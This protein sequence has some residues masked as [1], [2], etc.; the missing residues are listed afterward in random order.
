MTFSLNN[1]TYEID[2]T[3]ENQTKLEGVLAPFIDAAREIKGARN[4]APQSRRSA[5]RTDLDDIRAWA[6]AQGHNVSD[7]GRVPQSI[8]DAYEAAQ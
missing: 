3:Q 4:S 2:L 1:K 7:R 8:V 6:R 5:P